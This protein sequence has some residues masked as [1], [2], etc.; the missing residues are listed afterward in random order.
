[1]SQ[2]LYRFFDSDGNLLY[3]GITADVGARWRQH[4]DEK[5]WWTEVAH[6]TIEHHQS[7]EGVT[8][9]EVAAI[10]AEMPKYNRAHSETAVR[11]TWTPSTPELQAAIDEAIADWNE[12]HRLIERCW[13]RLA[14]IRRDNPDVKVKYLAERLINPDTGR[15]VERARVYRNTDPAAN[16]RKAS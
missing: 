15:P 11:T 4:S 13:A 6:A 5:P 1:M 3:V 2:A 9:A 12:G 10:K 8:A 16:Q 14:E 7:R